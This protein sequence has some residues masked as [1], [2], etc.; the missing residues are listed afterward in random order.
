MAGVDYLLQR[1]NHTI[2][3]ERK[4]HCTGCCSAVLLWQMIE[5]HNQ[6]I[7]KKNQNQLPSPKNQMS[8]IR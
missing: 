1:N 2:K 4:R 7:S 6:S 5:K 3:K 8:V